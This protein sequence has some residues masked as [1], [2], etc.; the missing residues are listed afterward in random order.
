MTSGTPFSRGQLNKLQT[1]L[2]NSMVTALPN[3]AEK[4]RDPKV[5]LKA[6]DGKGE[7]LAGHLESALE[8]AIGKMLMLIPRNRLSLTLAER[9]DPGTYYQTRTG[10]WVYGG[11]KDHIVSKAKSTKAGISFKVNVDDLGHDATDEE[12]ENSLPKKHLFDESAVC[13][14][15]AEMISKQPNGEPGDLENIGRVNLLYT[16][17]CVVVVNWGGDYREWNVNT[18]GRD[19]HRWNAGNRVLS[20]AN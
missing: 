1:M 2:S 5:V 16:S 15:V 7:I 18:W 19:V 10:L 12:I 9:H 11:F 4:F 14:I 6:L 8:Q 17:S 13:A 3:V 20:P